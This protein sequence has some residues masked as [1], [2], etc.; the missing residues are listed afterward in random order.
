MKQKSYKIYLVPI[1]A[2]NI[3]IVLFFAAGY[4]YF[5]SVINYNTSNYQIT[6][7]SQTALI[8]TKEDCG[9]TITPAMMTQTN[10][11]TDVAKAN[12]TCYLNCTCSGTPNAVCAYNVSLFETGTPYTPSTGIG[13]NKEF[14][15]Q[16]VN[17]I[18]CTA[19][20]SSTTETQVSTQRGK[21][22]ANCQLTV[23][24]GGSFSANVAAHFKWYNLDLNQ[25]SHANISYV[26]ALTTETN[27]DVIYRTGRETSFQGTSIV[28]KSGWC[29]VGDIGTGAETDSCRDFNLIFDSQEECLGTMAYLEIDATC[30]QGSVTGLTNYVTSINNVDGI[31]YLKHTIS[32]NK[33]VDS[34]A[35]IKYTE[36][37]V[38]KEACVKGGDASYYG[39]Y[40]GM[41]STIV[42]SVTDATDNI[43]IIQS[44]QSYVINTLGG[45]CQYSDNEAA[46]DGDNPNFHIHA[47][48]DG[49][50]NTFTQNGLVYAEDSDEC[51]ILNMGIAHCI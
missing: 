51:V 25:T 33:I 35:C 6:M 17:P 34:Y 19:Q 40:T 24:A 22:L 12:S 42:N 48:S 38:L 44:T 31:S 14:T 37:N 50:V 23:P 18:G 5:T 1:I 39:S 4:A 27:V 36:N 16:L 28:P 26:Y 29:A 15:V 3:F 49:T 7:P 32:N 30:S 20:N 41:S 45:T 47:V 9:V 13:T 43:R 8:C 2:I 11:N 10:W 46:C 21:I